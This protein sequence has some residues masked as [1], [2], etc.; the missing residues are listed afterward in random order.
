MEALSEASTPRLRSV[1]ALV[2]VAIVVVP[3]AV[4][5]GSVEPFSAVKW[6]ALA[7]AAA[8]WLSVE[9]SCGSDRWLPGSLR[10]AW[11]VCGGLAVLVVT[12]SFRHGAG[13]ALTPLLARLSFVMLVA[14]SC[15]S[16]RRGHL[17]L[18]TV[19]GALAAASG[20]VAS[21]GLLQMSGWNPLLWLEGGDGRSATFGNLNMAAQFVGLSLAV[22]VSGP[23]IVAGRRRVLAEALG[24]CSLAYVVLAGTRSVGLALGAA[25]LVLA[26]LGRLRARAV[27]RLALGAMLIVA[28]V[29]AVS[30]GAAGPVSV[31]SKATSAGMRL[32]V[33]SDT[34][35]LV[36][37]RP[38]GVGA[39]NF[40]HAFM[41]HALVGRSRPDETLVFRSPHN[42]YLRFLAEE[43]VLASAL[44]LLLG[45][46]LSKELNRSPSIRRWRSDTGALLAASS[47]FL[48]VEAFFQFPFEMA[49]SALVAAIL[50]GLAL[51]AAAESVPDPRRR[52]GGRLLAVAVAVLLFGGTLRTATAE[53]LAA[54]R[55]PGSLERACRLDPR[56]LE[57]CV[58]RAWHDSREGRHAAAQERL[59]RVLEP[60]PAY[61]PA[62]KL[63]AEDLLAAGRL[64]EGCAAARDYDRLL[65]G[66]SSLHAVA[67]SCPPT[68][69]RNLLPE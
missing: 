15:L 43:G 65:L 56:R 9:G 52:R 11:P 51:A 66:R 39:G 20:V 59:R 8:A 36:R 2:C 61:L 46:L 45:L 25:V 53:R 13:W 18:E 3:L 30:G 67:T 62:V 41:P 7:L 58:A 4:W 31:G 28:L 60:S 49:A 54:R 14:A 55:D 10:R 29:E 6:H 23:R 50:L 17:R 48:A 38:L 44:L 34:L 69:G 33:W 21:L 57:A 1:A 42:D 68:R 24:G 19:R 5:P 64:D 12:G 47:A 35:D 22:G 26:Q 32:A 40:E 37:A 16:F 27:G 63:R